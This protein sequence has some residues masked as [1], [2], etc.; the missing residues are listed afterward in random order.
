MRCAELARRR[1]L[2]APSLYEDPVLIEF[3]H[4]RGHRSIGYEDIPGGVPSHVRG[5]GE[6]VPG[7]TS[8]PAP[9]LGIRRAHRIVDRLRFSAQGHHNAALGI[10]LDDH[11]GPFVHDPDVV[12]RVDA[13]G[14]R[15]DKPIKSLP[16][17][18]DVLS[19][20]I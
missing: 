16:D 1:S 5:A 13:H 14:M 20:L 19:V 7:K 18:A 8:A 2:T 15:L 10:K 11:V 3:R 4:P 17:F 12:L 6:I 9:S